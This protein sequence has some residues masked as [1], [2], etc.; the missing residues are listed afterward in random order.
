MKAAWKEDKDTFV[1]RECGDFWP[2]LQNRC[3]CG[4]HSAWIKKPKESV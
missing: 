1:C 2:M 4:A 3:K